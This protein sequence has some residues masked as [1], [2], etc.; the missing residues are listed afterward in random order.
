VGRVLLCGGVVWVLIFTFWIMAVVDAAG[1]LQWSG[2]V[3]NAGYVVFAYAV[4][5]LIP[6]CL[7][8]L[9]A[10]FIGHMLSEEARPRTL[11]RHGDWVLYVCG[12]ILAGQA[13][14]SAA[15][16]DVVEAKDPD[17]AGLLFA[18]PVLIPLLAKVLLCVA[19][20][21]VLGR[22]LPIID[23]SRTLI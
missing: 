1:D 20:G 14:L 19:L 10:D 22:V 11:L 6:G 17:R 13:L 16:W 21:Q 18:G 12:A 9:I 3:R 5:F 8:L 7:A 23:E 15:G 2:L 4:S